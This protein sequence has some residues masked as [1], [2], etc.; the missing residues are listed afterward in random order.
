MKFL[1]FTLILFLTAPLLA[2]DIFEE[3]VSGTPQDEIEVREKSY[4]LNGYFRGVFYGG[5]IPEQDQA[6]LKSGY[7]EAA[8]KFRVRKQNFGD[9]F[10]D[11]RFRRGSEFGEY[12]SE[13]NLRE[14]YVNTYIGNFDFRFGYQ[15]VVWGR[16]DGLNPTDNISPKNMFIRSPNED[17]RREGNFLFRSFYNIQPFR[18]EAVWIPAYSASALPLRIAALPAGITLAEEEYPDANLK[19]S[20]AAVK[21]NFELA[22]F[23]GSLSYFNA[24]N[25]L[26]GINT[27]M[28]DSATINVLPQAYRMH[29]AGADFSTTIGSFGLRGELAYKT[30]HKNHKKYIYIPNPDLQYIVGADKEFGDFSIIFQYVGRYVFDFEKLSKPQ[31]SEEQ[32]KYELALYNRLF[33]SQLDEISHAVSFRPAWTLMYETLNLELLGLYNFTTKE[34]FIKPKVTYDI[35]D[36]L[37]FTLGG[38]LY[39]GSDETLYGTI[40]ESLSAIF[41]ELKTS[42]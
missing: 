40:D 2:Q 14:A 41:I 32:L 1:S 31:T 39:T 4:E 27:V 9:A 34:F 25:P 38:E 30:P 24:S 28:P 13:M 17:D 16:A 12:V 8:L 19:N 6:E 37:T 7:G 35:T 33:S 5:K 18:I 3:A 23:D 22:S 29:A 15:I 20:A 26:P 21:L 11:I 10:A 36:A 42:F